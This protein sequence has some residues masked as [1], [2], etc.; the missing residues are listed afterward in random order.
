MVE[1]YRTN[2]ENKKQA[3]L[4]IKNLRQNFPHFKINFDLED[5]DNILR[6]ESS[7]SKVDNNLVIQ[8]IEN[9]G[10][11]IE[12]L[13]DNPPLAHLKDLHLKTICE[14]GR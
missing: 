5:C 6:V 2:I 3:K 14:F 9:L 10:F 12:V 4:A 7:K 11:F 8:F 13:P 1:V